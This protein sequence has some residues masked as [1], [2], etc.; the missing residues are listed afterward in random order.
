MSSFLGHNRTGRNQNLRGIILL[1]AVSL[2]FEQGRRLRGTSFGTCDILHISRGFVLGVNAHSYIEHIERC[3][4]W[5]PFDMV[6]GG[7]VFFIVRPYELTVLRGADSRGDISS[8]FAV[9]VLEELPF[10]SEEASAASSDSAGSLAASFSLVG[11]LGIR[12]LFFI[13]KLHFGYLFPFGQGRIFHQS[14]M[15]C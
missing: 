11:A 14:N 15:P 5:G 2:F 4:L 12:G 3:G 9:R 8:L 1:F 6:R 7:R 10:S 13:N